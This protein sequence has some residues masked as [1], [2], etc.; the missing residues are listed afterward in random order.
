MSDKGYARPTVRSRELRANPTEAERRLWAQLRARKVAGVRFNSQFPIGPYIC[1]F[2]SR[3][4]RLVIEVDGGQHDW[5]A[6]ADLARTRFIE[7]QGFFVLRFCNNDVLENI[8]GVVAI[9]ERAL[10]DRPS[11]SHSR[12]REGNGSARSQGRP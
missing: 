3:T 4:A 9:I 12:K 6:A 8:E 2:V 10:A 7:T 5:N 11:P 1:D